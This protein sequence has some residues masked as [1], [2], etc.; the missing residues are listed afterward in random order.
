[1]NDEALKKFCPVM[2]LPHVWDSAKRLQGLKESLD[3]KSSHYYF[4]DRMHPNMKA[5]IAAHE[6]GKISNEGTFY[7]MRGKMVAESEADMRKDLV[8]TGARSSN[9]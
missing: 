9:L 1:M 6:T 4:I 5:V 7:L 8:W 3:P 2:P